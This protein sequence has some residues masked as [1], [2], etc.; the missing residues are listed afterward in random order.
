MTA[1]PR[2]FQT[3]SKSVSKDGLPVKRFVVVAC[4]SIAIASAALAED[5]T[6]PPPAPKLSEKA[7]KF[8]NDSLTVCAA[9]TKVTRTG[10]FH[11]LPPNMTGIVVHVESQ[12]PNCEG[13]FVNIV[14]AEG[15]FF[16]G[17]PWFLDSVA[18]EPTLEAKLKSFTW[19]AMKAHYEPTIDR[20]KTRDGLYKVTLT[21][22]TE[23]G[24]V[25]LEGAIDPAGTVFFLGNFLPMSTD[26]RT[27]RTKAF[28]PFVK[29]APTQGPA[30]A[31]VTVVEFS[32]FECPSCQHAAGYMKPLLAKYG[33]HLRYIRYDLP[34]SMHPWAFAAS[35]AGRAVW[36]Q[37]P[38]AFWKFKEQ[39][40]EN[41]EKLTAFT[42]DEFARNFAQDNDL[43]LKKYDADIASPELRAE[44]LKGAGAAFSNDIRATPTYLI[45]GI[46]VDSGD[47]G[48]GLDAYI[49]KMVK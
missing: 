2:P 22:V 23:R 25:P 6:P 20:T 39:V 42:F 38:E 13:Q 31:D 49:G 9:E 24:R 33:E 14:T 44:I 28:E 43:D 3:S 36:R 45:N 27:S 16:T 12:R 29:N 8:V 30:T 41:Q 4:L 1:A 34:L 17:L 32:D 40:Y 5:E 10:L 48:K 21:E 35:M 11:K 26:A 15:G 46:Q 47:N 7:E 18:S 19:Q 37:K